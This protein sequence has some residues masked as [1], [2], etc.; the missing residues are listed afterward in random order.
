LG[1]IEEKKQLMLHNCTR[2][3]QMLFYGAYNWKSS[4]ETLLDD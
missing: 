1:D 2:Q 3:A 4:E